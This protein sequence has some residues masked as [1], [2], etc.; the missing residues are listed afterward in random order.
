MESGLEEVAALEFTTVPAVVWLE[1]TGMPIDVAG[2]TAL[3]DRACAEQE[4]LA[5]QIA[6]H[7]PDVNLN[8]PRQITS[9]LAGLGIHVSDAQEGTLREIANAHPVVSLLL[10]H[11]EATK[12]ISTYGDGYLAAVHPTTGRIHADYHQIGAETGRMACARPNLQNIPR[13]PAYRSCIRPTSGR[14]LV[15][16]DLALIELCAAAELAGDER[17]LEAITT[18]QDLHRITAAAIFT[19]AP[20]DVTKEERAFG[21]TVNFGTLYGQGLR[22]LME[23]A[24][25][26]GLALSE[27]EARQIQQRFATAWPELAAWRQWQMRETAPVIQMPSGRIRRLDPDAPGTVR[28]NTPIQGLAAD[29]FKAALAELWASRHRCPSAKPVLAV[30]DELVVECDEA[31]ADDVA[32]WVAACL[33]TGMT[34][35]LTRVPVRVAVAVA[36][37]WSGTPIGDGSSRAHSGERAAPTAN[38]RGV[39]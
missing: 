16:A 34:R 17:M 25:K 36:R 5:H 23:A 30:H 33:Q 35:Y 6:E 26:Q 38:V 32:A 19:K 11:K 27:T 1:Q 14:V 7:L 29:G 3:R 21:K 12:R 20:E 18:G 24:H 28:A 22:G 10:A 39:A 9:A 2:W 13:D 15:K 31:D 4:R 8:S 37:D